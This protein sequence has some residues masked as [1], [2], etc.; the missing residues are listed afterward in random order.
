ML[1][2]RS[3]ALTEVLKR[4]W[5]ASQQKMVLRRGKRAYLGG[6]CSLSGVQEEA[7]SIPVGRSGHIR[8]EN[9]VGSVV[10][11]TLREYCHAFCFIITR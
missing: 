9:L 2:T 6:R 7:V 11:Y 4:V 3:A 5:L 1:I 10:K 8:S